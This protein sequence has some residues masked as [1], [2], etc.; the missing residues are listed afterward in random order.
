M[1][2]MHSR[3]LKTPLWEENTSLRLW[4]FGEEK[5]VKGHSHGPAMRNHYLIHCVLEGYGVFESGGKRYRLGPGD[6][7]L[8]RPQEIIY[9]EADKERPWHYC[10][11]G[12]QGV[13]AEQVVKMLGVGDDPILTF[14]GEEEVRKCIL[15]MKENFDVSGSRFALLSALYRFLSLLEN[16]PIKNERRYTIAQM[17]ANYILE[18]YSYAITV[19]KVASYVGVHRS[20]LFREFKELFGMSPQQYLMEVR[21]LKAQ[22]LLQMGLT[23]TETAYSVG[24]SDA[25]NFSR[26]FRQHMG[27]APA[28]WRKGIR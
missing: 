5:C 26:Q 16:R 13:E 11:V 24:F 6:A 25:T 19:E 27:I 23:V 2:R 28:F 1:L 4:Q 18:N 3:M 14:H 17:A 22:E 12:F 15:R 10:W 9:Y 7:F 8:I 21:L 20:Q